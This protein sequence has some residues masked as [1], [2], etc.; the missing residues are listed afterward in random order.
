ML[1]ILLIVGYVVITVVVLASAYSVLWV[2][3]PVL[4][5]GEA[6][7]EER[8]RLSIRDTNTWYSSHVPFA[9]GVV[10]GVVTVL[11]GGGSWLLALFVPFMVTLATSW[12]TATFVGGRGNRYLLAAGFSAFTVAMTVGT[13]IA[14]R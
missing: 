9:A 7:H 3:R 5:R 13:V 1:S 11:I 6:P 14:Y 4:I 12:G 8:P 10:S 2:H